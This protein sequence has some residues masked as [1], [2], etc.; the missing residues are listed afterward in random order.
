MGPL[1]QYIGKKRSDPLTIL[2]YPYKESKFTLYED[3]GI[4]YAY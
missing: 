4:T 2:I 3:D 1:M